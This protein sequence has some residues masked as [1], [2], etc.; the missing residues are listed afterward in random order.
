MVTATPT[1]LNLQKRGSPQ[2]KRSSI[3]NS[4]AYHPT[5][6]GATRNDHTPGTRMTGERGGY[7]YWSSRER[8]CLYELTQQSKYQWQRGINRGKPNL[9][10]V[11]I[12]LSRRFPIIDVATNP[13]YKGRVFQPFSKPPR[14]LR[15][16]KRKLWRY[17]KQLKF[18]EGK[19]K[20]Q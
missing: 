12:E 15:A 1:N 5:P 3:R 4:G 18:V 20:E 11:T 19:E 14:T 17:R 7:V 6:N 13:N 9:R 2:A 16:V 8:D 10:L